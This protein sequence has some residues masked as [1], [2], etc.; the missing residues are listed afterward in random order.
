M[1]RAEDFGASTEAKNLARASG[2]FASGPAA[3]SPSVFPGALP[4]QDPHPTGAR[5]AGQ[6]RL[7]E[8]GVGR[9]ATVQ[10]SVFGRFAGALLPAVSEVLAPRA[11]KNVPRWWRLRKGWLC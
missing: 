2:G 3:G 10:L 4:A 7:P 9:S 5:P 6:P 1:G 11:A 8:V